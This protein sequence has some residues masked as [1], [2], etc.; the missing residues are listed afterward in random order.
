MHQFLSSVLDLALVSTLVS[1]L[2]QWLKQHYG[3]NNKALVILGT[4]SIIGG[5]IYFF[6]QS[7]SYWPVLLADIGSILAFANAIYVL[8]IQWFEGGSASAP[9]SQQ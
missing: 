9:T 8:F 7:W 5:T 1:A 6:L 2:V 4:L 3:G